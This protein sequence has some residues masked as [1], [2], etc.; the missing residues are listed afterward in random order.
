MSSTSLI[1]QAH[2]VLGHIEQ[3]DS[4]PDQPLTTLNRQIADTIDDHRKDAT[5]KENKNHNEA[6]VNN[7]E[8]NTG[9]AVSEQRKKARKEP[10]V[11]AVPQS[12][13][14]KLAIRRLSLLPRCPP[15]HP[16]QTEAQRLTAVIIAPEVPSD[17]TTMEYTASEARERPAEAL[18][19]ARPPTPKPAQASPANEQVLDFSIRTANKDDESEIIKDENSSDDELTVFD[20]KEIEIEFLS[21]TG[22][23]LETSVVSECNTVEDFFLESVAAGIIQ[24]SDEKCCLGVKIGG[25]PESEV[26]LLKR[27]TAKHLSKLDTKIQELCLAG[28]TFKVEV[29]VL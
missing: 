28:V 1:S 25:V 27:H 12:K 18:D 10:S 22:Q 16:P 19:Q 3:G 14:V 9:L 7:T 13:I 2:I 20:P 24:S 23:V 17:D 5:D 8:S 6:G 15:F 11:G 21:S 26:R 4:L 29:K